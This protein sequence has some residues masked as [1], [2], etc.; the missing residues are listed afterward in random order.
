[1]LF[2]KYKKIRFLELPSPGFKRVSFESSGKT[3]V[4]LHFAADHLDS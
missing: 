2:I 1:M 4:D 3:P